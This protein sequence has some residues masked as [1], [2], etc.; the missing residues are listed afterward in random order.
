MQELLFAA[1]RY[2]QGGAGY[3]ELHGHIAECEHSPHVQED[4]EA[5]TMVRE[6]REML[7]LAWNEWGIN[8]TA[9]PEEEFRTWLQAQVATWHS[10][11]Q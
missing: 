1:Q 8:K 6:W 7:S 11:Q 10:A 4:L 9:I 2:L 3:T 5:R